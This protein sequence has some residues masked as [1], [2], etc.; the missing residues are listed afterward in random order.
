MLA[1]RDVSINN[2]NNKVMLSM[3]GKRVV[4]DTRLY[5]CEAD[6]VSSFPVDCM[7]MCWSSSMIMTNR[8]QYAMKN[9]CNW[10]DPRFMNPLYTDQL[11]A[12]SVMGFKIKLPLL[13]TDGL[14]VDL[15]EMLKEQLHHFMTTRDNLD[16][17]TSAPMDSKT[18]VHALAIRLDDILGTQLDSAQYALYHLYFIDLIRM[19]NRDLVRQLFNASMMGDTRFHPRSDI[20]RLML[21]A[22]EDIN[23]TNTPDAFDKFTDGDID[24]ACYTGQTVLDV[25]Q[26]D[27]ILLYSTGSIS[28]SNISEAYGDD[29]LT[30][31]RYDVIARIVKTDGV[32]AIGNTITAIEYCKIKPSDASMGIGYND[33]TL[34]RSLLEVIPNITNEEIRESDRLGMIRYV[35]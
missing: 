3:E 34:S 18:V 24:V 9:R 12:Q 30:S 5:E 26:G 14:C 2:D 11:I 7:Q 16:R 20:D 28:M 6:L 4:I 22:I 21:A 15:R 1:G 33:I 19:G 13:D 10:F 17:I 32:D 27:L 35:N 25:S 8:C 29:G 23:D 31:E